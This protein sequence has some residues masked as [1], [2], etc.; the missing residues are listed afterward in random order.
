M[1]TREDIRSKFKPGLSDREI[2]D[3]IYEL[4]IEEDPRREVTK[5]TRYNTLIECFDETNKKWEL[6]MFHSITVNEYIKTTD[7]STWRNARIYA[8]FANYDHTQ[9]SFSLWNPSD[10]PVNILLD[11]GKTGYCEKHSGWTN[12]IIAS[13]PV[14]WKNDN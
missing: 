14:R 2:A 3:S 1:I 8:C 9:V 6:R 4:I 5:H 7:M 12:N 11:N 10:F 13:Y